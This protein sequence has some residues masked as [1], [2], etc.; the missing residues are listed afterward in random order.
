MQHTVS[1]RKLFRTAAAAGLA[2]LV[3]SSPGSRSAHGAVA[4]APSVAGL[5]DTSIKR[6]DRT[7]VEV[8]FRPVPDRNMKR[9]L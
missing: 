4:S 6:V 7:W 3:A 8:P 5:L 2:G 1:R 9:E